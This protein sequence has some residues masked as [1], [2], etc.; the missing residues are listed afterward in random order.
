M[1]EFSA[2]AALLI[3][4]V[5][6]LVVFLRVRRS[7]FAPAATTIFSVFLS[8]YVPIGTASFIYWVVSVRRREKPYDF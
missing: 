7:E 3:A 2:Q 1:F 8:A 4:A 5:A 6:G